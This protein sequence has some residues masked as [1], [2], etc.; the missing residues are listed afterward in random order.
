MPVRLLLLCLLVKRSWLTVEGGRQVG[1]ARVL[2]RQSGRVAV[3]LSVGVARGVPERKEPTGHGRIPHCL[4]MRQWALGRAVHLR[5][6][7]RQ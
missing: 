5:L 2:H 7:P 6:V 3:A 4:A 1:A